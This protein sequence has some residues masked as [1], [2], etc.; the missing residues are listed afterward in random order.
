MMLMM[1]IEKRVT[2]AETR[3]VTNWL[4]IPGKSAASLRVRKGYTRYAEAP[5]IFVCEN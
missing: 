1:M 2:N 5:A 3:F 4:D